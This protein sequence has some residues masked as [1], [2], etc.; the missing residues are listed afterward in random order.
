MFV[1]SAFHI[2]IVAVIGTFA[3][4]APRSDPAGLGELCVSIA[5]PVATCDYG[6]K[7]CILGPDRGVFLVHQACSAATFIQTMAFACILAPRRTNGSGTLCS[8]SIMSTPG[9]EFRHAIYA[10]I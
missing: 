4:A 1:K 7:C 9:S 5:G 6:L 8:D 3:A 2:L 10:S